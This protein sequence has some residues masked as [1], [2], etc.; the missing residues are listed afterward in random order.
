LRVIAICGALCLVGA[1][2]MLVTGFVTPGIVALA[3]TLF[4]F[5]GLRTARRA[6][7]HPSVNRSY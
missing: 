7:D 5:I 3:G 6:I 2:V 1:L 4:L